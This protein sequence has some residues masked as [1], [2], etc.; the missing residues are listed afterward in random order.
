MPSAIAA[1]SAARSTLDRP[2]EM[3]FSSVQEIGL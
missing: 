3:I 2:P 1:S